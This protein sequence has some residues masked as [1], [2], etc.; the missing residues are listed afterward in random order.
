MRGYF[1]TDGGS[2][3]GGVDL[4]LPPPIG[5]NGTRFGSDPTLAFDS[6]GNLFYG[7]IVVIFRA[8]FGGINGTQM[9]VARS[10]DGGATYP[11]ANFFASRKPL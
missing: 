5:A 1:S 4:P 6:S 10:T 11:S 9:A 2:T 7:Y 8:N 3:W